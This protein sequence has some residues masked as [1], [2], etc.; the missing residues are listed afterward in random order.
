[1]FPFPVV[2]FVVYKLRTMT[3]NSSDTRAHIA[4]A[5]RFHLLHVIR[6]RRE[7]SGRRNS[8][9]EKEI[10]TQR[11]N[12][13]LLLRTNTTPSPIQTLSFCR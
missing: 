5:V 9:T 8:I 10:G 2:Y 7:Q 11:S 6:H 13:R 1:M 4:Y 3:P 12:P